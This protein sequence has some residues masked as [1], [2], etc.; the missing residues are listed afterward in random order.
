MSSHQSLG[1]GKWTYRSYY[2]IP[3][4][5]VSG[6]KLELGEGTLMINPSESAE[7]P[8]TGKIY[9]D[10]WELEIT[11]DRRFGNPVTLKLRGK[12]EVNG[13]PWIYDYLC[14]VVPEIPEGKEQVPAMVGA[15]TRVIE[16]PGSDGTPHRAGEVGSF[17]AVLQP[18]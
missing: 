10:G 1:V 11:G 14:Y 8:V 4:P 17:Y 13:H 16:H 18:K 3:N 5:D 7:G 6:D 12:G 2:N 15:V 9:G